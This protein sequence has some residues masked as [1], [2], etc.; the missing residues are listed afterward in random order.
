MTKKW[1]VQEAKNRFSEVM[2]RAEE[3]GPQTVTK[4]GQ[5]SVVIMAA[6]DYEKMR[7]GGKDLVEFMQDSPLSD[8]ELEGG[9]DKSGSREV[10]L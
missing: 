9:R 5:D 4:Y 1:Q 6:E 2:R 10:S 7:K 8:V 3:E